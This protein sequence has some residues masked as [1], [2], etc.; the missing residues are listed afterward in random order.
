MQLLISDNMAIGLVSK[1]CLQFAVSLIGCCFFDTGYE[2][3]PSTV[4]KSVQRH[5]FCVQKHD[6]QPSDGVTTVE[7]ET[8]CDLSLR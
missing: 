3:D 8:C 5:Q 4:L 2:A 7:R 1:L 6:T